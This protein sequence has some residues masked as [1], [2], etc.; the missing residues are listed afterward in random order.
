M[1]KYI[2]LW[3]SCL[4]LITLIVSCKKE[5]CT[6]PFSINYDFKADEDDGSCILPKELFLGTYDV[7]ENCTNGYKVYEMVIEEVLWGTDNTVGMM[8]IQD[9]LAIYASTK[10]DS[11]IKF[12]IPDIFDESGN[13]IGAIEGSGFIENDILKFDYTVSYIDSTLET[14]ECSFVATKK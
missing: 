3:M 7:E 12:F 2:F 13:Y 5:G 14:I 11:T 6:D 4:F 1:K 9:S 8:P 10:K